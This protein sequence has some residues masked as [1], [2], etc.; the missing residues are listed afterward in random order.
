[1]EELAIKAARQLFPDAYHD[2]SDC[3]N[4]IGH[5]GEP[6]PICADNAREWLMTVDRVRAVLSE[7]GTGLFAIALTAPIVFDDHEEGVH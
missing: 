6:C 3:K 7:Y 1:M 4:M 5:K 2:G